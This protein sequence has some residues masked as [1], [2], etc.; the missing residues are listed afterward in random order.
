MSCAGEPKEIDLD[1]LPGKWEMVSAERD[2]N[3][4]NTLD[5]AY[6]NISESVF[7]HNLNGDSIAVSYSVA[8]DALT[9]DDQM[10]KKLELI[11]LTKDTLIAKTKISSFDFKFLMS[12]HVTK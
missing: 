10:I 5:K 2:G 1:Q 3:T 7:S 9:L 8:E 6:F 11:S 4:T 12:K